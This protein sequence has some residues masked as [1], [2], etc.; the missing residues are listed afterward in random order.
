MYS[1]WCYNLY[2][3]LLLFLQITFLDFKK[4]VEEKGDDFW[5]SWCILMF[6]YVE[7][8]EEEL[9]VINHTIN[10]K[11]MLVFSEPINTYLSF[12]ES[13]LKGN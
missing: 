7:A 8:S 11:E 9:T 5:R 4:T 6:A 1:H 10:L 13:E 3:L 2:F 12:L